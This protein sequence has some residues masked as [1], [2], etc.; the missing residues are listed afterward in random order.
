MSLYLCKGGCHCGN[1]RFNAVLAFNPES[2]S[3]RACDCDY[4]TMHAAT[5]LSDPD[6]SL[7]ISI[8]GDDQ[9]SRYRQGGNMAS[10][11]S[12]RICGVL[13]AVTHEADGVIYGAINTKALTGGVLFAEV[14]QASP[15]LLGNEEKVGRWK[16]VWFQN[17][18][19]KIAGV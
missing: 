1:I 2:F 11:I 7:E 10:F 6:G 17:V 9:V 15:K 13:V 16:E 14:K 8:K 19:I 12:C 4:C 3:P 18:S 5:Y